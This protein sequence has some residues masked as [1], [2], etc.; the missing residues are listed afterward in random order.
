MSQISQ[1]HRHVNFLHMQLVSW[2]EKCQVI[3]VSTRVAWFFSQHRNTFIIFCEMLCRR[4]AENRDSGSNTPLEK[5]KDKLKCDFKN[6]VI[7]V[8]MR[9]AEFFSQH[10]NTF[11]IFCEMLCRSGAVQ[12]SL[13]PLVFGCAGGLN[14]LFPCVGIHSV[15]NLS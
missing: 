9:V 4:N 1:K 10:Q 2:P 6:Q 5:Q 13:K 8:S 15:H 12:S 11:R 14:K 7:L 3:L